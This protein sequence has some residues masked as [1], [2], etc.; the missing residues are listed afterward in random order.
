MPWPLIIGSAALSAWLFSTAV[1]IFDR[2]K[3]LQDQAANGQLRLLY[4]LLRLMEASPSGLI[5]TELKLELCQFIS[6]AFAKLQRK[7]GTDAGYQACIDTAETQIELLSKRAARVDLSPFEDLGTIQIGLQAL[8]RFDK[9]VRELRLQK[10]LSQEKALLYLQQLK[11][12]SF[13]LEADSG[14][15]RARQAL[16][17]QDLLS[18]NRHYNGAKHAI[19][20]IGNAELKSIRLEKL[21]EA[22]SSLKP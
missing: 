16:R 15:L 3:E 1:H 20:Q 13:E 18:A 7:H 6:S 21:N 8:P 12:R 17:L 11:D 19:Q 9:V 22:A 14:T 2:Q 4:S 5:S 10:L